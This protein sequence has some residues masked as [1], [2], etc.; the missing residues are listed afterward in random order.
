M[1]RNTHNSVLKNLLLAANISAMANK[2]SG[3]PPRPHTYAARSL[4]SN[5]P[6]ATLWR[7]DRDMPTK[8][9]KAARRQ[10]LAPQEEEALE[11]WA[12]MAANNGVQRCAKSASPFVN[13]ES[14]RGKW[15]VSAV[16]C[17]CLFGGK[18]GPDCSAKG[19]L[20]HGSSVT[21]ILM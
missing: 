2:D 12:L 19:N 16:A 10:Y 20:D 1:W 13:A 17:A 14:M 5:V 15:T 8:K 7:R 3:N 9:D 4:S 6:V 21:F 18:P 11:S